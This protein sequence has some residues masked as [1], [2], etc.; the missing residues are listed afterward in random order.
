MRYSSYQKVKEYLIG[1][2]QAS[3]L[4]QFPG[5]DIEIMHEY[6]DFIRVNPILKS[7][8]VKE[9]VYPRT[10]TFSLDDD[11]GKAME[12]SIKRVLNDIDV[13]GL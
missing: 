2:N 9:N 12:L 1:T 7:S 8:V 11:Y 4:E 10:K 6:A 3:F 5:K 13:T